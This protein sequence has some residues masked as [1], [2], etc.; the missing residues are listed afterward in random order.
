MASRNK[1]NR[2]RKL[3][4]LNRSH[5]AALNLFKT[6]NL[7]S[8]A[9]AKHLAEF[10]LTISQHSVLAFLRAN[11][12]HGLA[13]IELGELLSLSSPN[14]TNVVDRLEE[15]GWVKRTEHGSD[16]RV[17]IIRLTPQGE[18]VEAR[19]FGIHGDRIKGMLGVLE[20]D[21]VEA[22]IRLL[23]KLR[24]GLEQTEWLAPN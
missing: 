19:V 8:R 24:S 2:D 14:I 22:L 20:E 13:L 1:R 6:D 9:M 21:E 11:Q 17:K 23:R 16:R 15:K 7:L 12:E 3:P 5:L 18:E 4:V 10:G